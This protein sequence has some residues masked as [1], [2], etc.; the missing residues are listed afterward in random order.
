M[1]RLGLPP[2]LYFKFCEL[3]ACMVWDL[4]FL[5]IL[6]FDSRWAA[7]AYLFGLNLWSASRSE[8]SRRS[9]A[10]PTMSLGCTTRLPVMAGSFL[11]LVLE[12]V[13]F[14]GWSKPASSFDSGE[15]IDYPWWSWPILT[16][17]LKV[18]LRPGLCYCCWEVVAARSLWGEM[19]LEGCWSTVWG[20]CIDVLLA[21][22][23]LN[24]CLAKDGCEFSSFC[25]FNYLFYSWVE[26]SLPY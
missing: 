22:F 1:K 6:R 12:Y 26:F 7:T 3:V 17:L 5:L 4:D 18:E 9:E 13:D 16:V 10:W 14:W 19:I 2:R 20:L 8:L 21:P 15:R 11:P 25:D 23:D 24:L